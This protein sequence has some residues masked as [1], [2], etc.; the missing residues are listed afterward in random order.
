MRPIKQHIAI[1][2]LCLLFIVATLNAIVFDLAEPEMTM[3]NAQTSICELL[4]A[5]MAFISEMS[6]G[7]QT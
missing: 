1:A 6:S 3:I 7:K 2:T 4:I 5:V